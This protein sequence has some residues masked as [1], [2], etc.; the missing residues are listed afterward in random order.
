MRLWSVVTSQLATLP[1]C[2]GGTT[3]ALSALAATA[4]ALLHVAGDGLHLRV[5][6]NGAD[7]GHR[8]PPLPH[9]LLDSGRVGGDRGAV[10]PRADVALAREPVTLGA[11]TCVGLLAELRR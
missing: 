1:R 6:P 4:E 9:D 10:E 2:Q 8:V 3:G 5:R 11:R 7:R